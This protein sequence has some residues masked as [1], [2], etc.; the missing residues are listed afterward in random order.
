MSQKSDFEH[1]FWKSI[2]TYI[3]T[4]KADVIYNNSP[5]ISSIRLNISF[6]V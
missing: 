2:V 1:P 4:N 3:I 6:R 5:I